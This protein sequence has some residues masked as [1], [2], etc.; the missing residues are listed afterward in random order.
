MPV[1][2]FG[3]AEKTE[4]A[5]GRPFGGLSRQ[6]PKTGKSH[7]AILAYTESINLGFRPEKMIS[8]RAPNGA[9]GIRVWEPE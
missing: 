9:L 5:N 4:D 7:M 6:R 1:V 3:G 2:D 8:V